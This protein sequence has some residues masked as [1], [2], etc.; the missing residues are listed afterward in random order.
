[1]TG[2]QIFLC[3]LGGILLLFWTILS[4][5]VHVS[6][7]YEDKLYL[8]VRYLFIRI[9]ILPLKEKKERFYFVDSNILT[10]PSIAVEQIN[11][12]IVHMA[13]MAIQDF[14]I[15]MDMIKTLDFQRQEELD[16]NEAELNF[17]NKELVE[18]VIT[19]GQSHKLNKKDK[20]YLSSTY[21]TI[22]DL[23]R[24]GDY[25]TNLSNYAKG[26]GKDGFP[27]AIIN[28]FEIMR[29]MINRLYLRIIDSYKN[30]RHKITKQIKELRDDILNLSNLMVK[31]YIKR[32][33]EN[34][35]TVV[36][37]GEYL[38]ICNDIRRISEHLINL[39]DTDYILN[40]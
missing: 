23:E 18:L 28:E 16:N 36:S 22:A 14:N 32:L 8:S 38:K 3:V 26:L 10:T 17:L 6:F 1:M 29:N 19:L 4:I 12:E 35:L 5:P 11:H 13:N 7:S 39:I 27:E 2:F 33:N 9:G 30:D 21:K 37:S 24:I 25:A 40:H 20:R 34:E 31:V 15:A